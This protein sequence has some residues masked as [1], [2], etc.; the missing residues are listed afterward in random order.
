M[1]SRKRWVMVLLLLPVAAAVLAA[2]WAARHDELPAIDP[3]DSSSFDS[4]LVRRG[5]DLASVG[6]CVVCHTAPGGEAFAGGL[7]L[8]TPFGTI[9]STNITPDAET[10]IGRWSQTA[11]RRAMRQGI[12]RTGR[13]LYPVFP[14]DFYTRTS[15]ADIDAI[16]A[17][18][19][20]QEAVSATAPRNELP[21]PFNIRPLLA[22]WNL[23]FLSPGELEPD[24]TRSEEWNQGAYL[25]EGLGHCGACHSP[26]NMFGAVVQGAKFSGG[27]AEGWYVP[28]L[29]TESVAPLPW[30]QLQLVNY[31]YDGWDAEHGIAAGPM[32][33]IV[34]HLYDQPEDTVFAMAAYLESWQRPPLSEAERDGVLSRAKELDWERSVSFMPDRLPEDPKLLRG[35]EVFRDQC[36]QCHK[37][38]SDQS[39]VSLALTSTINSPDPRNVIHIIFDGI[40][41]PRGATQR[42]MPS[43]GASLT[44]QDIEDLLAY[45]RWHFTDSP[46]WPDIA[47]EV[48]EKRASW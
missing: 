24:R 34:N 39:P 1:M 48:A 41:A 19:M 42:S 11:F 32:T 30:D 43:F 45:M 8:E 16:Y 4:D 5:Q 6:A 29:G 15:D 21:F 13:H 12:D 2:L 25:V 3:P 20:T 31:L 18:L 33:P 47:A 17:F 38:G 46:A 14:Y 44:D 27:E 23:L 26:R 22:G 36:S 7:P 40:R 37:R 28:A 9:H 10:G 35:L